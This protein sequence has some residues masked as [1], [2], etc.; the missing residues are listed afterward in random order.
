M[1]DQDKSGSKPLDTS[2]ETATTFVA[3]FQG[4]PALSVEG[5]GISLAAFAGTSNYGDPKN[6]SLGASFEKRTTTDVGTTLS[7][8]NRDHTVALINGEFSLDTRFNDAN[9][10]LDTDIE[11]MAHRT[12]SFPYQAMGTNV[13]GKDDI[14]GEKPV[15]ESLPLQMECTPIEVHEVPYSELELHSTNELHTDTGSTSAYSMILGDVTTTRTDKSVSVDVHSDKRASLDVDG[16]KSAPVEVHEILFSELKLPSS[17]ELPADTGPTLVQS[18]PSGAE[19]TTGSNKDASVDVDGDKSVADVENDKCLL[20]HTECIPI[21]VHEVPSSELEFHA[22]NELPADTAATVAYSLPMGAESNIRNEVLASAD[23][24]IDV[25]PVEV[26]GNNYI[27]TTW[28][29]PGQDGP[30]TKIAD[31]TDKDAERISSNNGPI[32]IVENSSVDVSNTRKHLGSTNTVSIS[33]PVFETNLTSSVANVVNPKQHENTKF[34]SE[35]KISPM[36]KDAEYTSNGITNTRVVSSSSVD[37]A[38]DVLQRLDSHVGP[39][40]G[41]DLSAGAA[42]DTGIR[43]PAS[44]QSMLEDK[45]N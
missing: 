16:D 6:Y 33:S 27:Q 24:D 45:K 19:F 14:S 12:E 22:S 42:L 37:A 21:E 25:Q 13:I 17:N 7:G 43:H 5:V 30:A 20:L 44:D 8:D 1:E 41:D 2:T 38:D 32:V 34:M 26:G 18:L 10:E 29:T 15:Y 9:G 40:T 36:S 31:I 4:E 28:K 23:V 39:I 35:V 3:S 11:S